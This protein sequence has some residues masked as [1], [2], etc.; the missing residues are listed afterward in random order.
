[1]RGDL[2]DYEWLPGPWLGEDEPDRYPRGRMPRQV[3]CRLTHSQYEALVEAADLYG[4]RPTTLARQ[5]VNRGVR[6]II[7]L[8]RQD[9]FG[10]E[11]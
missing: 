6:A 9:R 11:R 4:V 2:G 7:S 5:L 10:P 1:M 8:D 3:G